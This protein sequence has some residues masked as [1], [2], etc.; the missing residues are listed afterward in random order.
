M[1]TWCY[2][3]GSISIYPYLHTR[4]TTTYGTFSR[5]VHCVLLLFCLPV[6]E[7]WLMHA[8][9]FYSSALFTLHVD[10]RRTDI[11]PSSSS[12]YA[13]LLTLLAP[14]LIHYVLCWM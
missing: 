9:S 11:P 13:R 6:I 4:G 14:K 12:R 10:I 2:T 8:L 5:L 3:E 7:A 1:R